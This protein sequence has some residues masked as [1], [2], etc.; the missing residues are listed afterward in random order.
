MAA[1]DVHD[2]VSFVKRQYGVPSLW[3]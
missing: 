3:K 2:R 1:M